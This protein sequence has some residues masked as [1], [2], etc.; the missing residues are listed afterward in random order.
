MLGCSL[1]VPVPHHF[2]GCCGLAIQFH[3]KPVPH[4]IWYVAQLLYPWPFHGQDSLRRLRR[5]GIRHLTRCER[6]ESEWVQPRGVGRG[7]ITS[8]SILPL[9]QRHGCSNFF[10]TAIHKGALQCWAEEKCNPRSKS[11][12]DEGGQQTFGSYHTQE[13]SPPPS[14]ALLVRSACVHDQARR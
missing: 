11:F 7:E 13:C 8:I 9:L 6:E 3:R 4:Q 14:S 10:L 2:C 1:Q 5:L 12:W